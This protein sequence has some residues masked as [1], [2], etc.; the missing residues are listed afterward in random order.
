MVSIFVSDDHPSMRLKQT[1]GWPAI[2]AVT[3]KHW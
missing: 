1:P 2:N 3:I